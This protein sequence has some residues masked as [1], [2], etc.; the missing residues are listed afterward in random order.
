MADLQTHLALAG[1]RGRRVIE[2]DVEALV[3]R[4]AD[5]I[6]QLA[7]HRVGVAGEFHLALSGG[8]TPKL[9]YQHL[10]IDPRYRSM[11][12]D[13][14]HLWI[15][16][17]RCVP[18]DDEKS[19]YRMINELIIEHVPI[20]VAHVHPM[21]VTEQ[22]GDVKYEKDLRAALDTPASGGRLDLVLL[23]MGPDGHTAS[24]FPRTPG[25]TETERWVILNDGEAVMAPRPRMTMTFPLINNAR[26]I[27]LLVTGESKHAM[28]KQVA[29]SPDAPDHVQTLPV[30]GVR[31]AGED[32]EMTWYLDQA[33][34]TGA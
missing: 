33:A 14:T 6:C 13:S 9:L 21:P 24:L 11:P 12:W 18:F 27:G 32:S 17:E 22:A 1:L 29:D 16:D 19:N 4:V 31:P 2:P 7:R 30:T 8:S 15:V 20:G 3:D 23:G 5:D 34:A 28:L 10:V 26:H 25:L